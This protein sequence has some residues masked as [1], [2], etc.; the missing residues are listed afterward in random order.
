MPCGYVEK[1]TLAPAVAEMSAMPDARLPF[2]KRV[3]SLIRPYWQSEERWMARLLLV[4]IIG[5]SLGNVYLSVLFNEWHNIF[6][7][8]LQALDKTAFTRAIIRFCYL[9][10]IFIFVNVYRTYLNQM[11]QIKWRRWM[12]VQYLSHW[13]HKQNY[14]RMQLFG[15][16]MDNPDQRMAEDIAQF[17]DL[18]LSLALD[19][20]SSVVTLFSFITILWE[21][22]GAL[23]FTVYDIPIHIPGY[24][25]WV[26]LVYAVCGTL[27]TFYIGRPLVRLNF[28]QQRFEADFRYSLIR[29]REN[30]ESIAFYK[31][32]AQ[33]QRG[34]LARFSGIVDNWWQ[35]MKRQK[36]LNWFTSGYGQIAQIFPYVVAAPR[37]FAGQIKLGGLM[38][39]GS[40][41]NVLQDALSYLVNSYTTIAS[42][43]AVTD[44]LNGFNDSIRVAES[45]EAPATGFERNTSAQNAIEASNLTIRLPDGRVLLENIDLMLKSGD[46]LLITGI[47]G[48]GKSTLLRTLAGLWPFAQGRLALPE[49]S[50]MLFVPQKPYLPLGTLKAAL[51]YPNAPDMADAELKNVLALCGLAPLAD[52]LCDTEQWSSILSLGEQQRV[53]FARV[54]LAKPDF[55]FL[56]EATSALDEAAEAQL[57]ALLKEKLAGAVLVSVGHRSSLRAWHTL[58]KKLGKEG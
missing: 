9:A 6:Y 42:W 41:F 17:I 38:Q 39:T 13:L 3:W 30:S 53:A 49:Q 22:S 35:I 28:N 1:Y 43:K 52:K 14:Y 12:T 51:C 37:Y 21:L 27:L 34:F 33:E 44:R 55:V 23:D 48:S 50:R 5:L 57:Y 18:T 47:S 15:S 58:E 31:G 10:G 54:L 40:A 19:G 56:D 46:S 20:L 16:G 25:L 2:R 24:M 36:K 8:A 29:L 26:A 32:E 4:T 11:L 7:N 45:M